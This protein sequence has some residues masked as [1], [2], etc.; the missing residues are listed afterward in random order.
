MALDLSDKITEEQ[1]LELT[2]SAIYNDG[3]V[4]YPNS[5]DKEVTDSITMMDLF[6]TTTAARFVPKV[7]ERVVRD[8]QEPKMIVVPNLFPK[9]RLKTG[10]MIEIGAL[11]SMYAQEISEG[12][13]YPQAQ[14]D[15]DGGDMMSIIVKKYGIQLSFTEE[16]INESQWDLMGLWLKKAGDAFARLKEQ[17]ALDLINRMGKVVFDNGDASVV[18]TTGRGIDGA[19]NGTLSYDDLIT[20]YAEAV[21]NGFNPDTLLIH[22][23]AWSL[24]AQ[25]PELGASLFSSA[26]WNRLPDGGPANPW[27]TGLKGFGLRSIIEPKSSSDSPLGLG[28]TFNVMPQKLPAPLKVI[29]T[30][31]MPYNISNRTTDIALVDSSATGVLVQKRDIETDEFDDPARDIRN[32]KMREY[33]GFGIMEQGKGIVIAKNIVLKKNYNFNLN[34]D[35]G[36]LSDLEDSKS[37]LV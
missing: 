37:K 1:L 11:G 15:L 30:P 5:E 13:E 22:P 31:Y 36:S 6:T 7:I 29:V 17:N 33:Y 25:D 8:A 23:L 27:G 35:V 16:M 24:F 20:L 9:I 2:A 34:S 3:E 12:S 10:R 28:A 21:T 19:A 26:A 18:S 4:T 32:L 14:F